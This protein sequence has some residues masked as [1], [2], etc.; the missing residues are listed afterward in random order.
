MPTEV[1]HLVQANM[2]PIYQIDAFTSKLFGG[3]PAA[4]IPLKNGLPDT[5]MQ[6][7]RTGK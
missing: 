4:I 2:K 7:N 1:S 5:L 3:N 6:Q